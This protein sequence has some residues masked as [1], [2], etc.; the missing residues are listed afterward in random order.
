MRVS[1]KIDRDNVLFV[2]AV[3][4]VAAFYVMI[5]HVWYQIWPAAPAPF[6]SGEYPVGLTAQLTGWLYYGH[7]GV[8]AFI[9]VSGFCL[10]IPVLRDGKIRSIGRFFYRRCRRIL[11]PYYAALSLSIVLATTVIARESGSQWDIS[12]PVTWAG[13]LSH[14]LLIQHLVEPTQINYPLWSI[15]V[16]FHLYGLF[17]ILVLAWHK[18]GIWTMVGTLSVGIFI[19]MVVLIAWHIEYI[20]PSFLGLAVHFALGMACCHLIFGGSLSV[21]VVR[22]SGPAALGFLAML[23][24]ICTAI[25]HTRVEENLHVVD[26]VVIA[27]LFCAFIHLSFH[28][29]GARAVLERPVLIRLGDMSYSLYLTHAPV[30]HMLWLFLASRVCK[31]QDFV[32]LLLASVPVTLITARGF[33]LLFERPFLSARSLPDKRGAESSS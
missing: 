33:H 17:P 12:V 2:T 29:A 30:I 26:L 15:S 20:P 7:F 31:P 18:F 25:G 3:R 28:P 32:L 13:A 14:L 8:V 11:P 21:W 6:G 23:V 5:S 4:G 27:A 19:L 22:A 24:V 1:A 10:T 16:E 9:F